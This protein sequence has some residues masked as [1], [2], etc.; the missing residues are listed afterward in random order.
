MKLS[1]T[2]TLKKSGEERFDRSKGNPHW[3]RDCF[4][5]L[6][7]LFLGGFSWEV[8]ILGGGFSDKEEKLVNEFDSFMFY[9][10][11]L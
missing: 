6:G 4:F 3:I 9:V 7:S 8:G 2:F 10:C 5:V 11:G 1:Q